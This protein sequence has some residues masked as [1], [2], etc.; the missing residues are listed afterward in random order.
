MTLRSVVCVGGGREP[1][2]W[3]HIITGTPA[4]VGNFI[5]R[6]SLKMENIRILILNMG[7]IIPQD[8]H[9]QIYDVYRHLPPGVK[10]LRG[11]MDLSSRGVQ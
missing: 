6:G 9:Q 3:Q 1:K 8:V 10:I 5:E 4:R 11:V 2:R 7:H